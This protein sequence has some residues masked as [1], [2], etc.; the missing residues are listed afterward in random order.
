MKSNELPLPLISVIFPVS[1][2]ASFLPTSLESLLTQ[3]YKNIEIIA[4]DDNSTDIS[5]AI[6][7]SY[8]KNDKRVKISRNVKKYGLAIT[9]NRAIRRAKG[10]FL[11]FMDARDMVTK[12]KFQK[13]IQYLLK[14]QKT[15]AVGTQCIYLNDENKR[16]GKSNY[17]SLHEHISQSP[18]HGVSMLFE[19]VMI[20]RY[21]IPKDL[22]Y[23]PATKHFFLYSDM[24]VK[25]IQFGEITNLSEYLHFH[26]KH[27]S[28]PL[29]TTTKQAFSL[30]K[31]WLSSKF[32]YEIEALSLKNL[33][34]GFFKANT[35][36]TQ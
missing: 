14:N 8:K 27:S 35:S 23:F 21:K 22:L 6:L 9:L 20:N 32:D 15:V 29:S 16:I 1:N 13:Q 30:M 34:T 25:L 36:T 19:G 31:L 5:F 10:K 18:L 12:N 17:P 11:V 3:N 2:A 28:T 33:F 7:K 24:A 4:I 26:R